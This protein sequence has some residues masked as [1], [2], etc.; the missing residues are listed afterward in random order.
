MYAGDRPLTH[1]PRWAGLEAYVRCVPR[2]ARA[3]AGAASAGTTAV[4]LSAL[5]ASLG[6]ASLGGFAG[7]AVDEGKHLGAFLGVGVGVAV[8]GAVLAGLSRTSKNRA[9]GQ[10]ID[11]MNLYNDSVGSLGATCDD[12]TYPA[13]AGPLPP[14]PTAPPAPTEAPAPSAEFN[15]SGTR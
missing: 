11:A 12:L 4:V 9:N 15:D 7:F 1:G 3:A 8:L 14:A 10:A 13:P 6:V 5:G 2:A